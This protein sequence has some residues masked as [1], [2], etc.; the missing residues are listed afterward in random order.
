[1]DTENMQPNS[2]PLQTLEP[3]TPSP[4]TPSK[5]TKLPPLQT[6]PLLPALP[7][8]VVENAGGGSAAIIVGENF[9]L[10]E[11]FARFRKDKQR[12]IR[13]QAAQTQQAQE[14]KRHQL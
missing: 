3:K 11:R 6:T 4:V 7:Q 14:V 12:V 2:L 9:S 13:N 8:T 1:M 5:S 10:Q